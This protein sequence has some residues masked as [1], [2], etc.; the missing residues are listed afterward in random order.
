[1]NNDFL[2]ERSHP[3]AGNCIGYHIK[4]WFR[5]PIW[6]RGKLRK[7]VH[8]F[9]SC[10]ADRIEQRIQEQLYPT[11]VTKTEAYT[12]RLLDDGVEYP[13]KQSKWIF[14]AVNQ[15]HGIPMLVETVELPTN[16]LG[17]ASEVWDKKMSK[18]YEEL[19]MIAYGK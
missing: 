11:V 18:I 7:E 4:V 10:A 17:E 19:G 12:L 8:Y 14:T 16:D 1:M 15:Y 6:Y 13:Y 5:E 2:S 9:G 3:E